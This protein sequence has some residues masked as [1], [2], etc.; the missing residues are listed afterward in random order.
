[1]QGYDPAKAEYNSG[2][3]SDTKLLEKT[4]PNY[5]RHTLMNMIQE[6]KLVVEKAQALGLT[7]SSDARGAASRIVPWTVK[8]AHREPSYYTIDFT[9]PVVQYV[10]PAF[11]SIYLRCRFSQQLDVEYIP[12]YLMNLNRVVLYK[13]YP[14]KSEPIM[15]GTIGD[16][17]FNRFNFEGGRTMRLSSTNHLLSRDAKMRVQ[18]AGQ[19]VIRKC[20]EYCWWHPP[21]P[22]GSADT[23]CVHN[24]IYHTSAQVKGI[25]QL[26]KTIIRVIKVHGSNT[27]RIIPDGK[28]VK[29]VNT[30]VALLVDDGKNIFSE[31]RRMLMLESMSWSIKE[32]SI[33]NAVIAMPNI[34]H[35]KI[36]VIIGHA[37][38]ALQPLDMRPVLSL[39][40]WKILQRITA[41][42]SLTLVAD[43]DVITNRVSDMLENNAAE[44]D[45][46]YPDF[47]WKFTRNDAERL[48]SDLFPLYVR[49][50][51][52]VYQMP[53][54]VMSF[55]AASSPYVL[56]KAE[57]FRVIPQLFDLVSADTRRWR[58]RAQLSLE[59]RKNTGS[60]A[61][62][63]LAYLL[64]SIPS[65]AVEVMLSRI[66][67][68]HVMAL[69]QES[70]TP[71]SIIS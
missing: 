48:V 2:R 24:M 55:L 60:T 69:P 7:S 61:S 64:S 8:G 54:A 66:F 30:D 50:G 35:P 31:Q 6:C 65:I 41:D 17:L 14:D 38:E 47:M 29:C 11:V 36:S 43:T 32:G 33:I 13:S 4:I 53:P 21:V 58:R 37:A 10:P 44:S 12:C 18:G 16:G 5:D 23:S 45:V 51:S 3:D 28:T 39:A 15:F 70:S 25:L 19:D 20:F 68:E 46:F 71:P 62:S 42:S 26:R 67:S 63:W 1:M 59:A 52:S 22:N 56:A 34:K 57:T 27:I 49:K 40:I 9:L